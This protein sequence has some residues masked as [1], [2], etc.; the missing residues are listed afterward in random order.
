MCFD[1][2]GN[3]IVGNLL[4]HNSKKEVSTILR[5]KLCWKEADNAVINGE[6]EWKWWSHRWRENNCR[7]WLSA[8]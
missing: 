1:D 5:E 7:Q 6:D 2:Y 8:I 4:D 3:P